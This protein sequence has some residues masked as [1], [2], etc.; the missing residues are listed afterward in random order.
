MTTNP[1]RLCAIVLMA[2]QGVFGSAIEASAEEPLKTDAQLLAAAQKQFRPLPKDAATADNPVTPERVSLGR[3]LFFDPRISDDGTVSC[4][5]CHLASLYGCDGL[6]GSIGAH[7][8]H[9]PR[10]APTVLNSALQLAIHW[11]GELKTVEEQAQKALIGPAFANKDYATVVARLKAIPG[12][13]EPF[14][15]AFPDDSNPISEK[16]WGK[17]IG[18]YERTLVTPS[19]FDDY[20]VGKSD[21]LSPAERH[22]LQLFLSVGCADCHNGVGI[23]GGSFEKFGVVEEYWKATASKKNDQGRKDVTQQDSDQY[24]FKV[25]I[26]RNVAMTAPYFH[27]GSVKNLPDAVKVM[28]RVQIGRVLSDDEATAI[29][30]FLQALTGTLP[31]DFAE[32]PTLPPG[33]YIDSP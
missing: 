30:A 14:Q 21:S 7:D 16:N 10:N 18:A 17:A 6:A 20:L 26:L 32:S 19:R 1:A 29:V 12:Y 15:K 25:A 8:F 5:R 3:K 13:A 24:V 28:S 4:H 31:R 23:G 22:G 33:S 2:V 27:D 11:R 9:A